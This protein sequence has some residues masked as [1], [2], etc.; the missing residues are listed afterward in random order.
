MA[1]IRPFRALRPQQQVVEQVATLPYDV[2]NT[3]EAKAMAEGN[4]NSFLHGYNL[5]SAR[6]AANQQC[7]LCLH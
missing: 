5:Y 6:F 3:A 2:M 1:H 7:H 4:P